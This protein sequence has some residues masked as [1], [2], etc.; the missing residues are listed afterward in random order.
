MFWT[1]V[2]YKFTILYKTHLRVYFDFKY[3]LYFIFLTR[4]DNL[5]MI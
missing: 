1:I 4:V 5:L 2:M 3:Y